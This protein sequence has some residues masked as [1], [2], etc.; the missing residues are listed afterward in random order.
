MS[1]C[2]ASLEKASTAPGLV[3]WSSSGMSST[4]L[5]SA[6]PDLLTRP[7]AILAPVNAY[8]PLSAP[9]PVTDAT[10]PILIVSPP[11]RAMGENADVARPA[12][13]L[14]FTDRLV[15]L[16][17]F[18]PRRLCFFSLGSDGQLPAS[19][20]NSILRNLDRR[21]GQRPRFGKLC[22]TWLPADRR[23]S[24]GASRFCCKAIFGAACGAPHG[25][26]A[27]NANEG[28]G[29]KTAGLGDLGFTVRER[30]AQAQHQAAA[31]RRSCLEE[32]APGEI[33]R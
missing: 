27:H 13:R 7:S 17:R 5:P 23:C 9:G 33:V 25:K 22:S 19:G 3:V 20:T 32:P 12:A 24:D 26:L 11:A 30:Q 28:V 8:L 1:G 31:G 21:A 4:G 2:A 6:P 29:R 18:L 14:M 16:I 10:I 15:T